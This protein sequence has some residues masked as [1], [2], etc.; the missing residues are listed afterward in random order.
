MN[1]VSCFDLQLSQET[2]LQSDQTRCGSHT[3]S[4]SVGTSG[5]FCG[6]K[7]PEERLV[8]HLPLVPGLGRCTGTA[9]FVQFLL[10]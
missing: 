3:A 6:I 2:F 4:Y 10:G 7:A 1:K 5:C 9:L 8:T